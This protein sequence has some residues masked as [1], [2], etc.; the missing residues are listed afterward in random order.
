MISCL[1]VAE[2]GKVPEAGAAVVLGEAEAD[3]GPHSRG[4]SL[5]FFKSMSICFASPNYRTKMT[6]LSHLSVLVALVGFVSYSHIVSHG[7]T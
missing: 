7:R 5:S 2:G 1:P 6:S 3:L 4:A